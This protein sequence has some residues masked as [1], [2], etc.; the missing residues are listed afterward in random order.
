MYLLTLEEWITTVLVKALGW[1]F[2]HSIWQALLA[3][4][5]AYTSLA[6]M[7]RAK[8]ATRYNF[9]LGVS[10]LF[11]LTVVITFIFQL[12]QNEIAEQTAV[13]GL[14]LPDMLYNKNNVAAPVILESKRILD[15]VLSYFN[16]YLHLFVTAWFIIFCVKWLR[17]S[18]DLNYVT[19]ISRFESAHVGDEWQQ[20]SD[21]LKSGLGIAGKV[22]LL[23]SNIVKV[24][25]V[26]GVFKPLILVPAG[27]LSNMPVDVIESILL[28]ELA[29][30]KRNDYLVNI[31]QS[32]TETVFFFNPFTVKLSALIREEREACC[33]AIA[34]NCTNNKV[35]YVQALVTF[36]EYSTTS[37]PLLAFAGSENHLLQRV[38]RILY[39]QNKKPGF[40]EKS[41]LLSSVIMFSLI[42]AF[43]SMRNEKKPVVAALQEIKSF[44]TDTVP[45]EANINVNE[46]VNIKAD[47]PS[48]PGS[49]KRQKMMRDQERKME[50]KER[51]LEEMKQQMEQ[52]QIQIDN[53]FQLKN[54]ILQKQL[55]ELDNNINIQ[56]EKL[57]GQRELQLAQAEQAF[58]NIDMEK[59]NREVQKALK[60]VDMEK[61]NQEVQ[62]ATLKAMEQRKLAGAMTLRSG[63]MNDD[64]ASILE[65]LED[66]GVADA[67]DVKSFTLNND[68]LTVNGKKQS[69]EL[70]QKLKERYIKD[71]GDHILYSNSNGSKSITIKRN[72]PS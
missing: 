35:S 6:V 24:P 32:A 3:L 33:D 60:A 5:F 2:I 4:L 49:R 15:V 19:R 43:T 69:S 27:M 17:L 67:D 21:K 46:N 9:L 62:A 55:M 37:A 40:M 42:T 10:L 22:K 18:I 13:A 53:D 54:E 58:K 14:Q 59:V 16:Q 29:H 51:K 47:E 44:V 45:D 1:T 36:G 39:N 41:I 28:H 50:K 34:V 52:I 63:Y 61:I 70:H 68:E 38:K 26:S 72:D 23:Q 71:K 48:K 25:L 11:I 66:N 57:Q 31:I 12:R 64:V 8:A 20:F 65:F 30:I 56:N 7:K